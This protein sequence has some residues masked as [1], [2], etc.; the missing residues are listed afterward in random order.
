[1][2]ALAVRWVATF[3]AVFGA[4]W[5]GLSSE[6]LGARLAVP[7]LPVGIAFGLTA[8]WGTPMA[9]AVALATLATW[10]VLGHGD[11]FA[12]GA[13]AGLAGG[14]FLCRLLLQSWDFDSGFGSLRDIFKLALALLIGMGLFTVVG[15]LGL[16]A[17]STPPAQATLSYGLTWWGNSIA[18]SL[19]YGLVLIV[20]RRSALVG[21]ARPSPGLALWAAGIVACVAV[22]IGVTEPFGRSLSVMLGVLLV[23]SGSIAFGLAPALLAALAM[24]LGAMVSYVWEH[25]AFAPVTGDVP[26]LVTQ[27]AF[28]VSLAGL[29]LSIHV[30]LTERD[31][32][33]RAR[34]R[35]E[36]RYAQVFEASPQATWV[37]DPSNSRFLLVNAAARRQYGYT[38]EQFAQL[39]VE[40]LA[41][42]DRRALPGDGDDTEPFET[43]HR[44]AD[45]RVLDVELWSRTID[46]EGRPATL[47]FALDVTE[48]RSLGRALIEATASEQRRIAEE[49]HDGLGQE[50]T[51]LALSVRALATKAEREG[52]PLAAELAEVAALAGVCIQTSR[53]IVQGL[54]PLSAVAQRLELALE[55][56]AARSSLSGTPVFFVAQGEGAVTLSS[57]VRN[58]LYRIAQEA[59]QNALKHAAARRIEI[60]LTTVPHAVRLEIQDDGRGLAGGASGGI[61]MR[62][63][64]LRAAA[65]GGRLWIQRRAEGGVRVACEIPRTPV[66]HAA[67]GGARAVG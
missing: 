45:G 57:E 65:I 12:F 56:L 32:A 23:V 60:R 22:E 42:E 35:A 5:F 63:M 4:G 24:T 28:T 10:Y 62:T 37:H 47:V 64:R 20:T 17:S 67:T 58:H 31:A 33:A 27:W 49:L 16:A 40:A 53:E 13:A 36:H 34:L 59:T 66:S 1:M 11:I 52:T 41:A 44:T 19:G 15:M 8:R 21:L 3:G 54:S 14:V 9:T 48:R 6:H 29:A 30:L 38:I 55:R 61:G 43:R 18:G 51:G 46:L 26:G 25:G 39:P 7:L 50:L 2:G